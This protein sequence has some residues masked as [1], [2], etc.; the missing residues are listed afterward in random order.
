MVPN[1]QI[2]SI[3]AAKTT[4]NFAPL[5][6]FEMANNHMGDVKHATTIIHRFQKIAKKFNSFNFAFKLQARNI[7]TFIHPDFKSRQDIKYVKRF[8]ETR[9]TKKDYKTLKKEI[10]KCG[11]VSIC[12]P[13]DEASVDLIEE[14][15]F[16]I[17]KIA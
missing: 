12:T 8:S 17:I 3:F 2:K 1:R 11:F 6:I 16:Q 15:D 9:L 10:E 4:K 14:L 5:V 13:F 7:D